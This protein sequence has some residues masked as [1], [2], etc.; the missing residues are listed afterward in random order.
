MIPYRRAPLGRV[1]A[2]AKVSCI[3]VTKLVGVPKDFLAD[4]EVAAINL[5]CR[6]LSGGLAQCQPSQLEVCVGLMTTQRTQTQR[7]MH[8]YIK[9]ERVL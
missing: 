7:K 2:R 3:Q 6:E 4:V 1:R 5:S 9:Y 8:I